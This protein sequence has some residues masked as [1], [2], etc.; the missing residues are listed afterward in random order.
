MTTTQLRLRSLAAVTVTALAVGAL[1]ACD[2]LNDTLN[3]KVFKDDSTVSQKITSVRI[4]TESGGVR[5]RGKKRLAKV[6]LHREVS[7]R[8]TKPEGSTY[9][10]EN[11]VLVLGDCG[12]QCSV[13]YT[14]DV[15]AGIPVTGSAHSG[16]MKLSAVGEVK[17]SSSN[18]EIIVDGASGPVDVHTTNG[19][20]KA[21]G[22]KG[23]GITAQTSNGSISIT[24]AVAQDVRAKT[25]NGSISVTAPAGP[26]RVSAQTSKGNKNIGIA[27]SPSAAHHL[28][29]TTSNG[30]ITLKSTK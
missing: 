21:G 19:A 18:G 4:D 8:G 6:S 1:G 24:P 20:I 11:G 25:S 17:V 30:A 12:S 14:V 3:D 29:L 26:Y 16:A 28:D 5:L 23:A 2:T 13:D 10:V 9:R 27:D 22:L 15:P 7:Y